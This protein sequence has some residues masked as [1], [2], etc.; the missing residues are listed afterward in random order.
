[1]CKPFFIFVFLL[2]LM[3]DLF[4][5]SCAR[6]DLDEIRRGLSAGVPIESR[7]VGGDTALAAAA[8]NGQ[9]AACELLLRH[10]ANANATSR[11]GGDTPMMWAAANGH[12]GVIELLLQHGAS[13]NAV[14]EKGFGPLFRATYKNQPHVVR[15]LLAAG[16]DVFTKTGLGGARSGATDGARL[17]GKTALECARENGHT[18]CARWLQ[19]FVNEDLVEMERVK[20]EFP[21]AAANYITLP[22]PEVVGKRA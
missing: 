15:L 21:A 20:M 3:A 6:G 16:A 1:L 8:L 19:A 10:G 17:G 9:L 14:N 13:V 5:T 2:R 4:V 12:A 7:D 22:S 11:E 18:E